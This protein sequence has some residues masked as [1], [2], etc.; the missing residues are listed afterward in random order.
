MTRFARSHTEK[1]WLWTF[2]RTRAYVASLPQ[3]FHVYNYFYK[4]W[5]PHRQISAVVRSTVQSHTW[6]LN[7]IS[8]NDD[9]TSS[10][11]QEIARTCAYFCVRHLR[12]GIQNQSYVY[13]VV[14]MTVWETDDVRRAGLYLIH[15]SLFC[16]LHWSNENILLHCKRE[17]NVRVPLI[18]FHLCKELRCF[19]CRFTPLCELS[20]NACCCP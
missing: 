20:S 17:N 11:Y 18:K 15:T 12:L 2:T 13:I 19:H 14:C 4:N 16:Q 9:H 7:G 10:A 3:A 8:L 5:L 1:L 6:F